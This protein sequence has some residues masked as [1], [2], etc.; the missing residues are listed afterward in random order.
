MVLKCDVNYVSFFQFRPII[1]P[2]TNVPYIHHMRVSKCNIPEHLGQQPKQVM[3]KY[4][5]NEYADGMD[6]F[7]APVE[8]KLYCDDVDTVTY[9]KGSEGN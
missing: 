9:A 4:M 3:E 1:R 2:A 5:S 6:C 7:A 8:W